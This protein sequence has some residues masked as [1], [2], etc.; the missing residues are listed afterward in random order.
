MT[1]LLVPLIDKDCQPSLSISVAR[2][3]ERSISIF[4]MFVTPVKKG[5]STNLDRRS[6]A[7]HHSHQGSPN[8]DLMRTHK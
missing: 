7:F 1:S 6:K 3:I 4:L 8:S 2:Q 5:S